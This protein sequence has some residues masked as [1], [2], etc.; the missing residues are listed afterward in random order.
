M[1]LHH[2]QFWQAYS[3]FTPVVKA[4]TMRSTVDA[5]V[6]FKLQ[7]CYQFRSVLE[8][9]FF[10]GQTAGL[11]AE[12][13]DP[14]AVITCVD[15]APR[16]EIFHSVFGAVSHKVHILA[17]TSQHTEFGPQDFIIIDG[18][19]SLESVTCDLRKSLQCLHTSG[20]LAVNEWALPAVQ[21]AMAAV[22]GPT[23][24]HPFLK[25]HQSLMFHHASID[26]SEFLD[27]TISAGGISDIMRFENHMYNDHLVLQ[28]DSLPIF[29]DRID[30][31]DRALRDLDL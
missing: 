20:V 3:R 30:Y 28:V 10:E 31:F 16:P 6:Y 29:T 19:K 8:I 11:L 9:G 26:R 2:T 25:T 22:L 14:A 7:S 23:D 13:S 18:D 17:Q 15:P 27:R 12:I 1:K 5:W 4:C 24:W 21:Q